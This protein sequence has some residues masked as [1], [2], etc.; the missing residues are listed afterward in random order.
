LEFR[1]VLFRSPDERG[2]GEGHDAVVRHRVAFVAAAPLRRLRRSLAQDRLGGSRRDRDRRARERARAMGR[3]APAGERA[4]ETRGARR[5]RRRAGFGVPRAELTMAIIRGRPRPLRD[6][7]WAAPILLG[8]ASALGLAIAL[9][10]D[11]L[12]DVVGASALGIPALVAAWCAR[13]P[14]P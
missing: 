12:G 13:R 11:G 10:A 3:Q 7:T 8:A 14:P 5:I 1:R 4:C 2:H 6:G 9:V